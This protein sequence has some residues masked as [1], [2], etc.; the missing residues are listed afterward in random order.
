MQ[1][2]RDKM[3]ACAYL[4]LCKQLNKCSAVDSKLLQMQAQEIQV[5]GVLYVSRI[6]RKSNARKLSKCLVITPGNS[7]SALQQ[8]LAARQL[9]QANGGGQIGHVILIPGLD[10]LVV[11]GAARAIAFPGVTADPM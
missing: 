5:P 4:L 3:H 9:M 8:P 11:P 7:L 6:G 10:D 1:M 2:E